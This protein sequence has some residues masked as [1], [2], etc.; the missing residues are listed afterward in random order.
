MLPAATTHGVAAAVT[1]ASPSG[2]GEWS[3]TSAGAKAFGGCDDGVRDLPASAVLYGHWH[4]DVDPRVVWNSDG[5]WTLVM[6][7]NTSGGAIATP[8]VGHFSTPW[9]KP[10]QEASFPVLYLDRE[11][12]LVT[13]YQIYRFATDGT[14]TVDPRVDV[15]NP[16]VTP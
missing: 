4:R 3:R 14:T 16:A 2:G 7:L 13:G 15:G 5:T 1:F 12:G 9:S 8:T 10:Q 11:S 6:E